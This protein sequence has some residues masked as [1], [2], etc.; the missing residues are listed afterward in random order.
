MKVRAILLDTCRELLYR[1]T[2]L[3]YFGLV[4]L[5]HLLFILALQTDVANGV[6]ASMRVFGLEGSAG[7]E[8]LHFD[9]EGDSFPA[10][11]SAATFVSWVQLAVALVLFPI[12]VLLS[13]FATASLVPHMLEKG[14]IDLLLSKPVS[15]P[16]LFVS[17]YLGALLVA[18]ANLIYLVGGLGV[19]LAWKTGVWNGGFFL[20]GLTM[21]LYFA[22]LLGFLVLAGVLLRSTTISIMVTALLFLIGMVIRFPHQNSDWPHLITNRAFRFGAQ[23]A[24][25]TLYHV[26]PRT[27][28][29]GQIAW[30]LIMQDGAVAWG[31]ILNSAVAGASALALATLVFSRSDF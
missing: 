10:S 2:L 5:T 24:V 29:F 6:I 16:V 26:L 27:H 18:A 30:T 4:T 1:K 13:V 31:P 20:S 22:C 8:G 21:T 15:R 11:L 9:S 19:I 25:E 14:S 17:R 12:G 23:A 7:P 28:D 3:I